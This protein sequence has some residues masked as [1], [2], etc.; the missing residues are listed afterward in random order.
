MSKLDDIKPAGP[1]G[2]YKCELLVEGER[3]ALATATR[4]NIEAAADA[5]TKRER[6]AQ[7]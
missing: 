4:E 5:L 2:A 3:V 1:D 7:Q 6:K